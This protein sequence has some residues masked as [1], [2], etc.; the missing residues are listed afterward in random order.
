MSK[1]GVI[2][3]PGG[4]EMQTRP[5]CLK[6]RAKNNL[7]TICEQTTLETTA[8]RT[9]TMGHPY[10]HTHIKGMEFT[11]RHTLKRVHNR[12]ANQDYGASL[13]F[14]GAIS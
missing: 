3:E 9:K 14:I 7:R 10:G 12:Q 5:W 11:I 2:G 13:S 1:R 4:K 6:A 8:K